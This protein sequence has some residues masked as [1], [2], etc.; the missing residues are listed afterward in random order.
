MKS[1]L[2]FVQVLSSLAASLCQAACGHC[3]P[4]SAYMIPQV[5]K[6]SLPHWSHLFLFI[7]SPK[8]CFHIGHICF[9]DQ[10]KFFLLAGGE[11]RRPTNN[12][13]RGGLLV[14]WVQHRTAQLGFGFGQMV[15]WFWSVGGQNIVL[16]NGQTYFLGMVQFIQIFIQTFSTQSFTWF[17]HLLSFVSLF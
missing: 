5:S 13:C 3:V 14:W 2:L 16:K 7:R 1:W 6:R 8:I 11:L 10:M 4:L 15:K 12:D 17:T 9:V